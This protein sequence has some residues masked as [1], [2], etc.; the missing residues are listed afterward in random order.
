MSDWSQYPESVSSCSRPNA[1]A[2]SAIYGLVN[3]STYAKTS[4]MPDF[5]PEDIRSAVDYVSTEKFK[6]GAG[7][8]MGGWKFTYL[9]K[10]DDG[11]DTFVFKRK[12]KRNE[13]GDEIEQLDS[14]EKYQMF[15]QLAKASLMVTLFKGDVQGNHTEG[16]KRMNDLID[17]LKSV[18]M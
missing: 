10:F 2:G 13:N 18:N 14:A 7:L 9:R 8:E 6:E 16:V 4:T 15:I 12:A 1:C 17:Y 5:T 3:G 11:T